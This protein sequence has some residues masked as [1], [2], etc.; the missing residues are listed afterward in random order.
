MRMVKTEVDRQL[1]IE[2]V[3][4]WGSS[5]LESVL[6]PECQI[7]TTP[8]ID[9]L[10]GY[11]SHPRCAVAFGD[12]ICK[13]EDREKLAHAFHVE[14]EKQNQ[15]AVYLVTS[16][17]FAKWIHEEQGGALIP[18]GEECFVDPQHDPRKHSGKLGISLRGKLR[19][20]EKSGLSVREYTGGSEELEKKIQDVASQWIRGRKGPQIYISRIRMFAERYGKRWFYVQQGDQLVGVIILNYL[21]AKDGWVLDRLMTVPKA[22]QGTSELLV[23][24][25]FEALASEG[26]HYFTFGAS[27]GPVIGELMGFGKILTFCAPTIYKVSVQFFNLEGRRKFVEK[28]QPQT[29]PTFLAFKNP[30]LGLHEVRSLMHA[31][32]VS[33]P[34]H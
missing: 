17:A 12:P 1:L 4:R 11:Y 15:N 14:C 16:E 24:G 30:H 23:I 33:L 25:A 9:G 13:P 2:T 20:A 5:V 27:N 29:V 19:H 7:F 6:D 34:N 31:L 18:F 28:F 22:P 10:I 32:N 21:A 26:C 8:G 3:H